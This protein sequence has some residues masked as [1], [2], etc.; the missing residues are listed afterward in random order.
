MADPDGYQHAEERRLFY[1]AL[2]R[3]RRAVTLVAISGQESPF[4]VELLKDG[5]VAVDG[6]PEVADIKVCPRCGVGTFA[7]RSG[8]YGKF[9]GCTNFP[10][11]RHTAPLT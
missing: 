4:V 3:V 7:I 1:V 9:L 5:A 11:C 8:P 10:R 2:T 6:D